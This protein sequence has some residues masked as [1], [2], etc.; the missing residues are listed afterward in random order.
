MTRIDTCTKVF[1]FKLKSPL[2]AKATVLKST[3][4]K[5]QLYKLFV[6]NLTNPLTAPSTLN[7]KLVVCG[8]NPTPIEI[9][10][11]IANPRVEM[12]TSHEEAD[13]IVVQQAMKAI[14]YGEYNEAKVLSD[15]SDVF[16]LLIFWYNRTGITAPVYMESPK[17]S[18]KTCVDIKQ[19]ALGCVDI[20]G[21]ILQVH[22]ITGCDTVNSFYGIGKPTALAAARTGEY[23]LTE[24]GSLNASINDVITEGTKFISACYGHPSTDMTDCRKTVWHKKTSNDTVVKAPELQSLPPTSDSFQYHMLRAH[25]Q[26]IVW[27]ST[28]D[29]HPPYF[30]PLHFGWEVDSSR[31]F[32]LP[33]ISTQGVQMAPEYSLKLIKCGCKANEPC[34]TGRCSCH[35]AAL[36]CTVFCACY[37]KNCHNPHTPTMI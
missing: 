21:N 32:L 25:A 5:I 19:S 20:V 22:A 36:G 23:L 37:G 17:H 34:K 10:N 3:K 26:A 28:M 11:N 16:A 14:L 7:H 30:D 13:V 35:H 24:L 8:E 18:T 1:K 15:D 2:P 4:N 33:K 12:T 27:M 9:N 31:T 29:A 6:E